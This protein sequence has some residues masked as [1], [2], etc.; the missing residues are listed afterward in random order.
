MC[1]ILFSIA[2]FFDQQLFVLI[3]FSILFSVATCW[4]SQKNNFIMFSILF[5]VAT[6]FSAGNCLAGLPVVPSLGL[7]WPGPI[8]PACLPLPGKTSKA[9]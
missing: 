6:F 3:M 1:S 7:V 8:L 4:F 2:T 5:S 9:R